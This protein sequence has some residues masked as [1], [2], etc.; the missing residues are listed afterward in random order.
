MWR[1][2]KSEI[3]NQKSEGNPK[4]EIRNPK[5]EPIMVLFPAVS[6]FGLSSF[7]RISGF[8]FRIST[9]GLL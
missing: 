8:G 5:S 1:K 3:R 9:T 2:P 6:D 7:L 4:P